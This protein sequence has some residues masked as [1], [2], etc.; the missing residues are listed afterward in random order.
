[1]IEAFKVA[2][3]S[4]VP[5]VKPQRRQAVKV[6]V[7]REDRDRFEAVFQRLALEGNQMDRFAALL[8]WVEQHLEQ[9]MLTAQSV[10]LES[11]QELASAKTES[12]QE[13][14]EVLEQSLVETEEAMQGEPDISPTPTAQEQAWQQITALSTTVNR[15]VEQ[16][17]EER[18]ELLKFRTLQ[19]SAGSSHRAGRTTASTAKSKVA[20]PAAKLVATGSDAEL[21][22]AIRTTENAEAKV[23][24]AVDAIVAYNNA[25]GRMHQE[26]WA[27]GVAQLKR[28]TRANQKVIERVVEQRRSEIEKHHQQHELG[29]NHNIK[30]GR[31]GIR[32]ENVVPFAW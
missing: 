6:R 7:W 18:T 24:A 12:R 14:R 8:K 16:L 27:F 11:E 23:N 9:P 29:P 32:I 5:L 17:A 30:K 20:T 3:E 4:K 28:L 26:K 31:Q 1:M 19:P 13:E 25:L 22:G 21:P 15:L 10:E 2:V